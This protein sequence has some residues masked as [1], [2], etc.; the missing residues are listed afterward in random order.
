MP[1]M[2]APA[3]PHRRAA[4]QLLL[5]LVPLLVVGLA[6]AAVLAV[7]L[8]AARAPLDAATAS[9]VATVQA[10][11]RAPGG[12]GVAVSLDAG[13]QDRRGVLV[14]A[15]A[16]DATGIPRG[17]RL[18]VSYD[19]S[20]PPGHT[21]VYIDGDAAHKHVQDLVFG[22][23]VLAA[24]LV[25]TTTLTALRFVSRPRLR[26]APPVEVAASRVV[27]RQGL[28]V[29]SW[30]ELVTPAGIR[31]L[32]VHW[33]PELATLAPG[34][35]IEVRGDPVR[36][37]LVLPVVDGAELWPSGRL[38]RGAPRGSREVADPLPETTGTGWARQVRVDAVLLAIAPVLG[39]LWAYVDGTGVGG[40]VVATLVVAGVLFWLPQLLGSDPAPP[41][42]E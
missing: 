3:R 15:A 27:V 26:R 11:G 8:A 1:V 22:L 10:T 6:L 31:W 34:S 23:V 20:D 13:G 12:R 35:A 39:L 4:R 24:V 25:V 19:P 17:T 37:R 30:L 38:R 29:R 16:S 14:L 18:G 36:G 42:R 40:F 21:A 7:R 32:P 9:G 5:G 33:S 41:D 2:S 28:L